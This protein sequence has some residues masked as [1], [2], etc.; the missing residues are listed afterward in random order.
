[1]KLSNKTFNTIQMICNSHWKTQVTWSQRVS[2]LVTSNPR[3]RLGGARTWFPPAGAKENGTWSL[4]NGLQPECGVLWQ[5]GCTGCIVLFFFLF[6][7]LLPKLCPSFSIAST[8]SPFLFEG[9][10]MNVNPGELCSLE[11]TLTQIHTHA[12]N[13][14]FTF[15]L[16]CT[17]VHTLTRTQKH[18]TH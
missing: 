4:V 11:Y 12:Q 13:V 10:W 1:M 5:L 15:T 17:L 8:L 7:S 18:I 16:A 3:L 9:Q 2:S 6:F 14:R